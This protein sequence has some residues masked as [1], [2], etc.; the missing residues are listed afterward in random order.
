M[1][2]GNTDQNVVTAHRCLVRNQL[3]HQLS[4]GSNTVTVQLC[5]LT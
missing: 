2:G 1:G 5:L 4:V 3:K